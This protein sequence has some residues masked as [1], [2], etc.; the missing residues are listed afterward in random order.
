M[1]RVF[2]KKSSLLKLI[3]KEV[4]YFI[5]SHFNTKKISHKRHKRI[6]NALN[7]ELVRKDKQISK[8]KEDNLNFK[9]SYMSLSKTIYNKKSK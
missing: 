5:S 4:D 9:R 6:V 2:N 3:L 8:L 1:K 7:K